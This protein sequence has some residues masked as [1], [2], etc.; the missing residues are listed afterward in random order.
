MA[1]LAGGKATR[2]G[3]VPKGLLRVGGVPILERLLTLR[4]LATH[5][6]LVGDWLEAYDG[7][8]LAKVRDEVPG[9]GAPGGVVAALRAARTP[10]V[11]V[12]ACDMPFVTLAAAEQLI[13]AAPGYRGACYRVESRI[14]PLLGV[15][16]S[17]LGA[18]WKARLHENPSLQTLVGESGFNLLPHRALL[19]VDPEGESVRN[20]N[21]WTDADAW[22]LLPPD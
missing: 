7:W 11:L 3:G 4:A 18:S 16:S 9:Q 14:E 13:A 8:G 17:G 20:I 21:T 22:G 12:V 5:A 15:Y 6:I 2:M 1:I 10:W 19:Q